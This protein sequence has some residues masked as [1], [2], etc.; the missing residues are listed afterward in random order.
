MA[1]EVLKNFVGGGLVAAEAEE[2][3]EVLDPA[4]EELLGRV[5]LSGEED[6]EK[7]VRAASEAFRRWREEPVTQRARRMFRL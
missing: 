3:L 7:V 4:T 2:E 5:P 6:V 1:V